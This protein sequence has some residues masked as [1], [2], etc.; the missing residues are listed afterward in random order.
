MNWTTMAVAAGVVTALSTG[1][2]VDELDD[3]ELDDQELVD[4]ESV[5]STE[6]AVSR[7]WCRWVQAGVGGNAWPETCT[8][9][10]PHPEINGE[11]IVS[12]RPDS[13]GFVNAAVNNN[14]G[15]DTWVDME[16]WAMC[17]NGE[18]RP[19]RHS[20]VLFRRGNGQSSTSLEVLC[21][22]G[23]GISGGAFW[24]WPDN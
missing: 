14:T 20:Q 23:T 6:Q 21:P 1:C 19:R 18:I 8:G 2:V 4:G 7:G 15:T 13:R 22:A 24:V 5:S 3:E 12:Y 17:T 10:F 9:G 11:I 16:I